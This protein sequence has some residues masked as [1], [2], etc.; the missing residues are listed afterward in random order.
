MSFLNIFKNK[1]SSNYKFYTGTDLKTNWNVPNLIDLL[2]IRF[3]V[4]TEKVNSSKDITSEKYNI[5]NAAHICFDE[6]TADTVLEDVNKMYNNKYTYFNM[7]L[8]IFLED[9]LANKFDA[10]V[11]YGM[12]DEN[13]KITQEYKIIDKETVIKYEDLINIHNILFNIAAG[14]YN[15]DDYY[16]K[17]KDYNMYFI[18]NKVLLDLPKDENGNSYFPKGA[19]VVIPNNL[20]SSKVPIPLFIDEINL[21]NS[22]EKAVKVFVN[23]YSAKKF[24][25][26][27]D[28]ICEM[29]LWKIKEM[30]GGNV[31]IE[32]HRNWWGVF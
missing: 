28:T 19:K 30:Y 7:Y 31:I 23:S 15:K 17:L 12:P 3:S 10:V 13:G 26:D 8:S 16:E 27:D 11:I 24:G 4:I 20:N 6:K 1:A 14:F 9:I 5:N 2:E 18:G 21:P 29:P 32:P 25:G 22:N